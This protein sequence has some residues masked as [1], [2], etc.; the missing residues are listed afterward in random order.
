MKPKFYLRVSQVTFL[1][2]PKWVNIC[3]VFDGYQLPYIIDSSIR[4]NLSFKEINI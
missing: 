4:N 3:L 2:F 1:L